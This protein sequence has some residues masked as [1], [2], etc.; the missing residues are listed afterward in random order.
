M[1][2]ETRKESHMTLYTTHRPEKLM[3]ILRQEN[4]PFMTQL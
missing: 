4:L 3:R 2:K 1:R